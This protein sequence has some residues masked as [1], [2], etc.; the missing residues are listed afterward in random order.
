ME[1]RVLGR[2]G[3]AVSR[4]GFGGLFVAS[5]AAELEEAKRTVRC[6][7]VRGVN[8]IDTAPTYGNSEEV[9]G[10]ALKEISQPLVL[11]TKLGGRP[12]PFRPQDKDCLRASLDESLRLLGRD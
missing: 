7:V 4:L 6:A 9:I 11:S 2:S 8:Y 1:K 12:I 10:K 5:F 3:I